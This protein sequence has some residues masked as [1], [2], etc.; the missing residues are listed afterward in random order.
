MFQSNMDAYHLLN[1]L[2]PLAIQ[3]NTLRTRNAHKL[4][5]KLLCKMPEIADL[6]EPALMQYMLNKETDTIGWEKA[7]EYM[8]ANVSQEGFERSLPY[9]RFADAFALRIASLFE[10]FESRDLTYYMHDAF[11]CNSGLDLLE[12][13]QK[14]GITLS[15]RGRDS[16]E[17]PIEKEIVNAYAQ[18]IGYDD[19]GKNIKREFLDSLLGVDMETLREDSTKK[20]FKFPGEIVR[21]LFLAREG[22]L[23]DLTDSKQFE[24]PKISELSVRENQS[25][26]LE[27]GDIKIA[28]SRK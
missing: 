18:I 15:E 13:I 27:I 14:L 23:S 6:L 28:V 8:K 3:E 16:I 25:F 26:E 10:K 9:Y 19:K 4:M 20:D 17:N 12:Q 22:G 21:L 11:F 1:K 24:I 7:R 5:L 2:F